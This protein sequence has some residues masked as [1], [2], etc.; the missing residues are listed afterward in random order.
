MADTTFE[1]RTAVGGFHKGDVTGYIEYMTAQHQ[2]ALREYEEKISF[3]QEENR[4]LRQ[5]MSLLK[6][7][8]PIAPEASAPAPV[9]PQEEPAPAAPVPEAAPV[10][11]QS[12]D[13]LMTLEL[14]AYRRAVAVERDAAQRAK[15]LY[16]QMCSLCD[17]A[18]DEFHTADM[19]TK[20]TIELIIAQAKT[21]EQSYMILSQALSASQ[22]KL[23]AINAELCADAED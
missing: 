7:A 1:F 15:T 6:M 18:M 14:L 4:S 12:N 20:Q 17:S 11:S 2:A 9:A 16:Q 13:D 5:Q 3:L 10:S 22:A 21:L 23:A 19:A 8:T